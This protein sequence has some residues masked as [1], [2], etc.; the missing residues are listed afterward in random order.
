MSLLNH[1]DTK[2][3]HNFFNEKENHERSFYSVHD[4]HTGIVFMIK[5]RQ[6]QWHIRGGFD[7][8]LH[9]PQ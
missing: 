9:S 4:M 2:T 5:H 8:V 7:A 3:V 6:K 1:I